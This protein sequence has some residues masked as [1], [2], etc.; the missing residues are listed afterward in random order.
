MVHAGHL[1]SRIDGRPNH[2]FLL[3]FIG[4]DRKNAKDPANASDTSQG[5]LKG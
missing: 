5:T 3:A 4:A 2:A 1:T